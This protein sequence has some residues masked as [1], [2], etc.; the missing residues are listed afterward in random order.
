MTRL[1]SIKKISFKHQVGKL[2]SHY[3]YNLNNMYL[4]G[5]RRARSE[6][7]HLKYPLPELWVERS[8]LKQQS[9][10]LRSNMMLL[11]TA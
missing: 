4:T 10:K 7:E 6:R 8:F 1:F 9:G 5:I 2:P 11:Y 3:Y